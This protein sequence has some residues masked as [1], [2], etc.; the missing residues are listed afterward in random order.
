MF[1]LNPRGRIAD[2]MSNKKTLIAITIFFNVV[3][4]VAIANAWGKVVLNEQQ[5]EEK[6]KA[7]RILTMY[8]TDSGIFGVETNEYN[9]P[10]DEFLVPG[11]YQEM[12]D[13]F[14]VLAREH[15]V[16]VMP[17]QLSKDT[18][19]ML[20]LPMVSW[21]FNELILICILIAVIML[22]RRIASIEKLIK[23]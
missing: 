13:K 19:R 8:I 16:Q 23:K 5:L 9:A 12:P 22:Y 14:S 18:N 7:G 1:C 11:N 3:L 10:S 2:F 4:A 15:N 20:W 6:L 21:L 17:S